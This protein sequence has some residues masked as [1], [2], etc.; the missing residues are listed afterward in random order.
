MKSIFKKIAFVL[1]LAMVVTMMPA[2]AAAAASNDGP[3]MYTTLKLYIGG[4]VT[5]Q[6]AEQRYAKVWN[7]GDYEVSFESE[8]PSI[9]KVNSKGYVT[10]VGVG[11]TT[12]TA[13]FTAEGEDD[14][15]KTCAVTVKKNAAKVGLGSESAKTVAEGIPAGEV[16]QLTA[17]RKD[18]EGHTEWNKSMKNYSTDSVR[19]SSSN[20]EVFTVTKTTGK[21]TAVKEGE[22]TLKVWT[23]QSEGFDEEAQEY[24]E[25]VSKEYTVK[26]VSK[27]IVAKQSAYNKFVMT[28]PS[29][30]E[31]KAA[32]D[33][34]KK[35]LTEADAAVSEAEDIIK[36]Y[37]V[38]TDSNNV[39]REVFIGGVAYKD[40]AEGVTPSIEVTMFNEMDEKSTYVVCYKD[41]EMVLN[42]PKYVAA[43]LMF[44]A[45]GVETTEDYSVQD[46]WA[47][48]YTQEGVLLGDLG[49]SCKNYMNWA[50]SLVI[51]DTN[52]ELVH[53]E[54]QFDSAL[55]R[56]WFYTTDGNYK[57]NL[58]ATFEDW[59]NVTAGNQAKTITATATVSPKDHN[60]YVNKFIDWCIVDAFNE[61]GNK[62]VN[63]W[64]N[65]IWGSKT[66]ASEDNGFYLLVKANI[67]ELGKNAEDKFSDDYAATDFFTFVSSNDD[68]LAVNQ[69]TG[70]L[71]PPKTPTS[72]TVGIHVY[73]KGVYVGTCPVQII[74]KRTF[75]TF[76]A[77]GNLAKM[78]YSQTETDVND[79]VIVTLYPKDQLGARMDDTF[80]TY[81]VEVSENTLKDYFV[82]RS[83]GY[84][85]DGYPKFKIT[86]KNADQLPKHIVNVRL[87]CTATYVDPQDT[88][89][90]ITKQYP[91]SFSFKDTTGG[92]ATNFKLALDKTS[93]NMTL[94]DDKRV[95]EKNV[96]IS[97]Y[98][99]DKDG[100][101]VKKLLLDGSDGYS[102]SI[103]Y[104]SI[105]VREKYANNVTY[106]D[107]KKTINFNP[108]WVNPAKPL[109]SVNIVSG[110]AVTVSGSAIVF[111]APVK[112]IEKLNIGNY[113][114]ALYNGGTLKN[115]ALVNVTDSQAVPTMT[116]VKSTTDKGSIEEAIW[117]AVK[118]TY[119]KAPA[120]YN[121]WPYDGNV[122][123]CVYYGFVDDNGTK[124]TINDG[125]NNGDISITGAN[126]QNI[127]IA[128]LRYAVKLTDGWYEFEIPV[129]R[130]VV[131]GTNIYN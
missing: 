72:G 110:S 52:T 40:G 119:S 100:F 31:A 68:K 129:K 121:S 101:K 5:G 73:Y 16:V 114:V 67:T 99:Y 13:T 88:S 58:K 95:S 11:S 94:D 70:E 65:N 118:I 17:L 51:E 55:R 105:D 109:A 38:L 47:N 14:V 3:Q 126:G 15:V 63:R 2:K 62:V 106:S 19:F 85:N 24:P 113:V 44:G 4:D 66:F 104:G 25:V 75:A 103:K 128:K 50:D 93:V 28:F 20:P 125:R 77:S 131:Y 86:V 81:N 117:D 112:V 30:E 90:Q 60:I 39:R 74:T 87:K 35:S 36:V 53:N 41:Q 84:N 111:G 26:V 61:D 29:P 97:A 82:V 80:M 6:I 127:Y 37:K 27:D 7:K 1:A 76:N 54:Y 102:V 33:E 64:T 34:T 78:S 71:Y 83:D 21:L 122:T 32:L 91:V 120:P 43:G 59:S 108:V 57:V 130:T 115:S 79:D 48:I 92:I 22:A 56:I 18:E 23:V 98:A 12:I 46:I 123:S 45:Y 8:D 10:A 49:A 89:K 107:D 116:W 42:T 96:G 124:V 69:E 9:A